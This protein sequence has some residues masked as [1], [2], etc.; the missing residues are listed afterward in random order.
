MFFLMTNKTFFE[1]LVNMGAL[2]IINEFDD[3]AGKFFLIHIQ[4]F[5]HEIFENEDFMVFN[6]EKRNLETA[7]YYVTLY[8]VIF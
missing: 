1:T 8:T 2:M 3:I 5:N 4:T 6:V 7:Y